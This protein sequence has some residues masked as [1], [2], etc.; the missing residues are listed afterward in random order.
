ML[1]QSVARFC[2]IFSFLVLQYSKFLYAIKVPVLLFQGI[3]FL[4]S[5]VVTAIAYVKHEGPR[6][7]TA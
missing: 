7:T 2:L 4:C 1:T 3:V 6:N 5:S